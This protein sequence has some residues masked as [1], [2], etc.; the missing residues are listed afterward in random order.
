MIDKSTN[1]TTLV[2]VAC[3]YTHADYRVRTQRATIASAYAVHV[4]VEE[5]LAAYSPLTHHHGLVTVN[6][7]WSLAWKKD[8]RVAAF[9]RAIL[10]TCDSLRVLQLPDW[11][12]SS[13][14]GRAID[15]AI[16]LGMPITYVD[17]HPL[18][19][20]SYRS[21]GSLSDFSQPAKQDSTVIATAE[22]MS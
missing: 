20:P 9:D 17:Q 18:S 5:G 21:V 15:E 3:P 10:R 2:Y 16:R 6:Y 14:V 7:A 4:W 22:P 8:Q 13:G 12:N 19:G 11:E 1:H